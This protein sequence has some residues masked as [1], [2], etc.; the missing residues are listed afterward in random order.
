ML[1]GELSKRSGFSRDTIRYYQTLGLISTEMASRGNNGYAI[2]T[3]STLERLQNIRRLK[4]CGF[5]LV[6]TQEILTT[7]KG[8]NA[9]CNLPNQLAVKISKLDEQ[10]KLLLEYKQSLLQI[11]NACSGA[12]EIRLGIPDCIPTSNDHAGIA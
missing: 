10:M 4:E 9:C 7:A 5:T 6:E 1:I 3:T 12:C 11:Q 2:Y 8:C